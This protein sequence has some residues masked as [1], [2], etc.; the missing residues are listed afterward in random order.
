MGTLANQSFKPGNQDA[1]TSRDDKMPNTMARETSSRVDTTPNMIGGGG[2]GN[3][4]GSRG[5]NG[6]RAGMGSD[7]LPS[8][9]NTSS[10]P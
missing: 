5:G 3:M 7:R 6:A 1:M 10:K 8:D 9:T 4:G 2:A